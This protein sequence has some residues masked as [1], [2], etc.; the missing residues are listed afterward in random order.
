M[1]SQAL[2]DE[3]LSTRLAPANPGDNLP[4]RYLDLVKRTLTRALIVGS[5]ERHSVYPTKPL[6]QK[7]WPAVNRFLRQKGFEVVRTRP[8]SADDYLESGYAATNRLEDAETML[9]LRQFDSMQQCIRDVV[10][11]QVP[12]DTLEAGVWRGGMAIFMRAALVA[13]G[14]GD[15][16]VWVA[17]SFA[18]LPA[19]GAAESYPW[20]RGEMAVSLEE[21]QANFLRYGLLDENVRFVKGYFSETL[22]ASPVDRLSI[23]RADADLYQSTVD[24]LDALYDRLSPGGYAIFDDYHNLPDCRRA[25][26]EFRSRRAITEPLV[27]ID[28]RAV[29]WKKESARQVTSDNAVP[30]PSAVSAQTDSH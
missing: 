9:G 16:K 6:L 19:I 8:A 3:R 25:I 30:H 14:A 28:R 17:D 12:G 23:L 29:L 4:D 7:S 20:K 22:A 2:T 26:D 27:T 24:I 1:D 21:V 13:Y 15:R 5:D 18:G 10:A 11:N